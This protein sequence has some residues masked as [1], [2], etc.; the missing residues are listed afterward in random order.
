MRYVSSGETG[1]KS[2]YMKGA[3]A[4]P[5]LIISSPPTRISVTMMGSNQNFL[6]T[7]MNR[8][9]SSNS[10]PTTVSPSIDQNWCFISDAG[11]ESRRAR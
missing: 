2:A 6:R 9:I 11:R 5:E 1:Q 7:L 10:S 8:Q 4:E 3:T